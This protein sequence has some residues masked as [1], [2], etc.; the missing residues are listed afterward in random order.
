MVA[1]K[2]RN[3][4]LTHMI[5]INFEI[6]SLV[7]IVNLNVQTA[8]NRF[9]AAKQGSGGYHI[10]RAPSKTQTYNEGYITPAQELSE[11]M[12][13]ERWKNGP[14]NVPQFVQRDGKTVKI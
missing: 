5:K 13:A 4:V 6:E 11:Q 2:I 14:M 8:L 9:E 12:E 1:V 7:T 3:Q 10:E